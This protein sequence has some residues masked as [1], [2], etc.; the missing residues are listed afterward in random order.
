[1]KSQHTVE[2]LSSLFTARDNSEIM[3]YCSREEMGRGVEGEVNLHSRPS[4][5]QVSVLP[6]QLSKFSKYWIQQEKQQKAI[7]DNIPTP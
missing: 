7:C 4:K 2:M 3:V 6:L 1:M 5:T